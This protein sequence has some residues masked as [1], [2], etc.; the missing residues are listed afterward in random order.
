MSPCPGNRLHIKSS[1]VLD[2]EVRVRLNNR[3]DDLPLW[4]K[5]LK[6]L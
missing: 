2:E 6:L 5:L 4:G 3:E 1:V